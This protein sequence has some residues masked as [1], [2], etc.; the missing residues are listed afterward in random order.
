[1]FKR[2]SQH[3]NKIVM[4]AFLALTLAGTA[5]A[6]KALAVACPSGFT[7]VGETCA[8]GVLPPGPAV[9]SV[10]GLILL[11]FRYALIFAGIVAVGYI[12]IGGYKMIRAGGDPKAFDSGKHYIINAAI[13]L[14]MIFL[15]LAIV[16]FIGTAVGNIGNTTS[17]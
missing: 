7:Q 1:M 16:R 12:I 10:M 5:V 4:P 6:Q 3:H 9:N 8:P 17:F 14:A 15:A 11:V 2:I 13:G